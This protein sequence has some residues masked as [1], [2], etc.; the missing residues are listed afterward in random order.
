MQSNLLVILLGI[1]VV[2]SSIFAFCNQEN[3]G[4]KEGFGMNPNMTIKMDTVIGNPQTGQLQSVPGAGFGNT[5]ALNDNKFVSNASY[6]AILSPRFSALNNWGAYIKYNMPSEK[7]MA[8][9]KNPLTFGSMVNPPKVKEGFSQGDGKYSPRNGV[10]GGI[11]EDYMGGAIPP[12]SNYASS[13]YN[14]VLS[15]L[16]NST[17][18]SDMLPIG[19]MDVLSSSGEVLQP[20]NYARMMYAMQRSR[21]NGLGD[22]IRGDLAIVP[23]GPQWFRPSVVPSIDLT[24]G[25]MMVMGGVD[26]STSQD[27]FK[28]MNQ[29]TAG[30]L[31]TFAG[32]TIPTVTQKQMGLTAAHGD[33]N[34]GVS[35]FP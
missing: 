14:E 4:V 1:F 10:E 15:K 20:V 3:G 33:V 25:A 23:C 24:Q 12:V 31:N 28:L 32:V 13:N 11:K 26:N 16:P 9:P 7:Q 34:V 19:T 29:S 35:A 21:L 22:R 30:L 6:Q 27:T 2:V 18:V 8:V 5:Y 17:Q